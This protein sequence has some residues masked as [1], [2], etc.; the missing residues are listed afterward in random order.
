M[1]EYK[2]ELV[3]VIDFY[4]DG[5]ARRSQIPLMN[6]IYEG[7]AILEDLQAPIEVIKAFILHPIFQADE[8]LKKEAYTY[9]LCYEI[10][11]HVLMY[12]MEYRNQANA[13]LSDKVSSTGLSLNGMPTP[14]PLRGVRLMLIADKVQNRKDFELYHKAT[15]E[16]SAELSAYF[17]TWLYTLGIDEVEYQRL[18]KVCEQVN[19]DSNTEEEAKPSSLARQI[20]SAQKEYYSWSPERRANC[21]L[22]GSV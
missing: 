15:H 21:R 20:M 6:H 9:L 16:R 1:R 17:S 11:P 12:L 10:E 2:D 4:K 13:W 3:R 19:I 18:V 8:N 5:K 7:I 14:G 22:E